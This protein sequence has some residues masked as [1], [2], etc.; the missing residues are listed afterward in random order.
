MAKNDGSAA[1]GR[2]RGYLWVLVAVAV[3]GVLRLAVQVGRDGSDAAVWVIAVLVV[4]LVVVVTVAVVLRRIGALARRVARR[5]PGAAVVP[6]SAAAEMADVAL[7]L[8]ASRRG[9]SG[10]GGSVVAVAVLPD[11]LEVWV[12]KDDEP[13]W[14]VPRVQ[15]ASV[16]VASAVFGARHRDAVQVTV[17]SGAVVLAVVPAYRPMRSMAGSASRQDL[18]RAVREISGAPAVAGG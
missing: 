7:A 8:G 6:A 10:Q 1:E 17:R 9:I 2:R 13:R 3:V 16:H 12:G 4:A 15:V 18:E 14:S 11:R 5:R